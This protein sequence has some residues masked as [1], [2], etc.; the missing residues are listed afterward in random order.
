MQ[1]AL[2]QG[3]DLLPSPVIHAYMGLMCATYLGVQKAITQYPISISVKDLKSTRYVLMLIGT[4][5]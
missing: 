4:V 2:I 1:E 5:K 3:P